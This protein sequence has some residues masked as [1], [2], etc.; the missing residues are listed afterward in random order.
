M[1]DE[2][3]EMLWN[4]LD[5]HTLLSDVELLHHYLPQS[6]IY[7]IKTFEERQIF[8]HFEEMIQFEYLIAL[9]GPTI[10]DT[11]PVGLFINVFILLKQSFKPN[12]KSSMPNKLSPSVSFNVIFNPSEYLIRQKSMNKIIIKEQKR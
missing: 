5:L 7:V 4:L 1:L 2:P 10:F 12:W 11:K 3:C 9:R 8:Q 6:M